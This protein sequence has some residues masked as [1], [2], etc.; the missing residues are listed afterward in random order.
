MIVINNIFLPLHLPFDRSLWIFL[1][2]S[3]SLPSLERG[4]LLVVSWAI[5]H[6]PTGTPR[7]SSFPWSGC[8]R[9]GAICLGDGGDGWSDKI[10][11]G[12]PGVEKGVFGSLTQAICRDVGAV[13][14]A[15]RMGHRTPA[16]ILAMS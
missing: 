5:E 3:L 16:R 2:L 4:A 7:F 15:V 10:P 9:P 12:M 13:S 8:G 14:D 11:G 1:S 6:R